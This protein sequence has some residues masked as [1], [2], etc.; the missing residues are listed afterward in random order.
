ME[1]ARQPRY[2]GQ[3]GMDTTGETLVTSV[4]QQMAGALRGQEYQQAQLMLVR[5]ARYG[6]R[7]CAPSLPRS[8]RRGLR[9]WLRRR[10]QPRSSDTD[11]LANALAREDEAFH[12]QEE[13]ERISARAVCVASRH[14]R[15]DTAGGG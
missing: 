7:A 5:L 10:L 3:A 13:Y 14:Y 11:A 6:E 2:V 1:E 15:G 9:A 12:R 4:Q 8:A